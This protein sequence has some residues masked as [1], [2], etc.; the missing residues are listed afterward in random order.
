M[1]KLRIVVRAEKD[2]EVPKEE[3]FKKLVM[4]SYRGLCGFLDFPTVDE[5]VTFEPTPHVSVDEDCIT[6]SSGTG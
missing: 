4:S 2:G 1:N 5:P 3:V 6:V